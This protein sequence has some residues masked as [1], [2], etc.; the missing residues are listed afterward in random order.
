VSFPGGL[1]DPE[2]GGDHVFTAMRETNEE[3]NLPLDSFESLG[4]H[5]DVISS[6]NIHGPFFLFFFFF[7]TLC[8]D[9]TFSL[10]LL[11]LFVDAM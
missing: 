11:L 8:E 10:P 2:D 4:L 5:H 9:L 3:L 1:Q 6:S 7:H